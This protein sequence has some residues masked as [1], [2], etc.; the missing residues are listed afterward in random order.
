MCVKERYLIYS[1]DS[2]NFGKY[3]ISS[4]NIIVW[5]GRW[6]RDVPCYWP[7]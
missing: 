6:K 3:P 5:Y 7:L 2:S 4:D 1:A